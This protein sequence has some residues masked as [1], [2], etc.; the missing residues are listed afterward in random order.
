[1]TAAEIYQLI[2]QKIEDH[3]VDGWLKAFIRV[4]Y[5][6]GSA[7]SDGIHFMLHENMLVKLPVTLSL[8]LY[9][10]ELHRITTQGGNNHWNVLYFTMSPG[11][12]FEV[13]FVLDESIGAGL[14]AIAQTQGMPDSQRDKE[15][16]RIENELA[17]TKARHLYKTASQALAVVPNEAWQQLRLDVERGGG[18]I[19][20]TGAYIP[21]NSNLAEAEDFAVYTSWYVVRSIYELGKMGA[22]H[23]DWNRLRCLV[24]PTGEYKLTFDWQPDG[25]SYQPAISFPYT[26]EGYWQELA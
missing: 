6:P 15:L 22:Y 20:F 7:S 26:R 16:T 21:L 19:K 5:T 3:Q 23:P 10:R 12:A 25:S 8:G 2:G 13:D 4:E 18:V 24:L 11:G 9:V 17:E 14:E 1:M